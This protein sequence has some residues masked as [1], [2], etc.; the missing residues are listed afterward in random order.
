M[1][2]SVAEELALL[3]PTQHLAQAG[4]KYLK[5]HNRGAIFIL[6][7]AWDGQVQI[8]DEYHSTLRRYEIGHLYVLIYPRQLAAEGK[9][10]WQHTGYGIS[11]RCAAFWLENAPF[12][13]VSGTSHSCDFDIM[14]KEAH[15]ATLVI[16][17]RISSLLSS[18]ANEVGIKAVHIYPTGMSAISHVATAL[19]SLKGR[20]QRPCQVAVFG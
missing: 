11:S 10:F 1:E 13:H 15:D 9:A 7:V 12:L 8:V 3:F 17:N 6:H 5:A 4:L 2:A 16:R 20:D 18:N 14:Q 19:H